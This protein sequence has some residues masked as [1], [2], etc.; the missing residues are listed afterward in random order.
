LPEL[1]KNIDEFKQ[2]L[3]QKVKFLYLE[4]NKP[5]KKPKFISS[6]NWAPMARWD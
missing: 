3:D 5:N 6:K 4:T 2:N 1:R